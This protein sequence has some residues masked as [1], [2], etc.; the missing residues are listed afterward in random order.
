[1][2]LRKLLTV[3]S[4]APK[5][6]FFMETGLLPI[7]FMVIKRRLLYL[8]NILTKPKSELISKVYEVQRNLF[9]KNDWYNL[10]T[11]NRSQLE[12]VQ[13]DEQN[14]EGDFKYPKTYLRNI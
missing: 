5:E 14:T 10:V 6:T 8:Q 2:L 9:S 11:E 13:S 7:K 1:M 4:K 12:I 3:H